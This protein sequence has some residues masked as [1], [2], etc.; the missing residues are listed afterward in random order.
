MEKTGNRWR[1]RLAVGLALAAM[2]AA[3]APAA[4]ADLRSFECEL[5]GFRLDWDPMGGPNAT[6]RGSGVCTDATYGTNRTSTVTFN[7]YSSGYAAD[8]RMI[9]TLTVDDDDPN[10]EPMSEPVS[11]KPADLVTASG[12]HLRSAHGT[13]ECEDYRNV[14]TYCG[15]E[16]LSWQSV[17]PAALTATAPPAPDVQ[18]DD[19]TT[20]PATPPSPPP[21]DHEL[22]A[23]RPPAPAL[24]FGLTWD[25]LESPDPDQQVDMALPD[26]LIPAVDAGRMSLRAAYA[27]AAASSSGAPICKA[28]TH[29]KV[30]RRDRGGKYV[31]W[32]V[33]D[34]CNE[35][36]NMHGK[37]ELRFTA[38]N[39]TAQSDSYSGVH[40]VG[41]ADGVLVEKRTNT[42]YIHGN[43]YVDAPPGYTWYSLTRGCYGNRTKLRHC[44]VNS[45]E[46]K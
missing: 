32:K 35:P 22:P 42:W 7:G 44:I 20:A 37:G 4:S 18:P 12:A 40:E 2:C 39:T 8:L 43:V 30:S 23:P 36:L 38:S 24:P 29:H 28:H 14:N 25:D 19:V 15:A 6:G 41:L 26:G 13:Y 34:H 9:G 10:H 1:V 46:F 21:V 16:P 27:E 31:Y 17:G 45:R 3:T 33:H 11:G 5:Q